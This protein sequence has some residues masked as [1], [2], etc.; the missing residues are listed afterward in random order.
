MA[1]LLMFSYFHRYPVVL[2][3]NPFLYHV[4]QPAT[5]Q[6]QQC[7]P[8]RKTKSSFWVVGWVYRYR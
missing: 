4:Y 3:I 6:Q 1:V 5:Q 8:A 7:W 2:L